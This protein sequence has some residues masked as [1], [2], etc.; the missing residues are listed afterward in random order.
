MTIGG[1]SF[2]SLQVRDLERS[3]AFY[4]SV[5]GL[6]RTAF[7]PPH[8]VV[9]DTAPIA[10]AVR[11]AEPSVDLDAVRLGVGISLWFHDPEGEALH[12]S[13]VAAGVTISREPSVGPFGL[14]FT[15]VDLDGYAITVHNQLSPA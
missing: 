14:T 9:F 12:T 3:A 8:A 7:S 4:E 10:F 11:D 1:P 15:F 5:V 6:T 13:L 2:I